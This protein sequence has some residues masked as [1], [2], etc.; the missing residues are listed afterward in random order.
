[1][2]SRGRFLRRTLLLCTSTF[3]ALVAAE[4]TYRV[5]R[6]GALSPTTHPAYVLHDDELGWCYRP[7][8]GARHRSAEFDVDV[9]INADGFRGPDWPAARDARPL[10]LVVG[11]S[12]AFGWGVEEPES[13]PGL[14]RQSHPEW[15]VRGVGVSGF[16][17]D[18]QLLLLRRLRQRFVP[19]VVVCVS[20]ANDAYEAATA[21]AYGLAKPRFA[22]AGEG[23]QLQSLPGPEGWLHA[24][25][26]LWRA[27]VKLEWRWRFRRQPLVEDWGLVVALYDAMRTELPAA[28]FVLVGAND[29]LRR[30]TEG[31]LPMRYV[32]LDD[33]FAAA[34]QWTFPV[35]THWNPAGHARVADAV[36]G[37]I[38]A[39]LRA[40][41]R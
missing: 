21:V 12:I 41:G 33:V 5:T 19:D 31:P 30:V 4:A 24:H 17:P 3:L 8:A 15:D 20:C 35:D 23:V 9:R 22:R 36:A 37:E 13:L 7:N 32:D 29:R 38:A 27:L 26:L 28:S 14:L 39:S 6:V 25:S 10:V 16:A 2:P 18:Q 11:D 40:R 34:G 1:M